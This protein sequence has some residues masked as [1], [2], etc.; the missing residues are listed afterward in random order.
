MD[1]VSVVGLQLVVILGWLIPLLV[2]VWV[3]ATLA[4]MRRALEAIARQ[5]ESIDQ[6]LGEGTGR[7]AAGTP[8]NT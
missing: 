6:K 4:G 2:V 7:G 3:I 8:R 5:L 1:G